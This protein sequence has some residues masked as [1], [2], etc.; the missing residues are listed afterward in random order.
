MQVNSDVNSLHYLYCINWPLLNLCN[1]FALFVIWN[2]SLSI[3][4]FQHKIFKL[5]SNGLGQMACL[6]GLS[7]HYWLQSLSTIMLHHENLFQFQGN[8]GMLDITSRAYTTMM[9]SH[10]GSIRS[11]AVDPLRKHIATVSEDHTIRV[12]DSDSLQQVSMT[13]SVS[14]NQV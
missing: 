13:L 6:C 11:V 1:G 5:N 4:E 10:V 7:R 8:L 9:R 14:T 12:W 2:R 3:Q